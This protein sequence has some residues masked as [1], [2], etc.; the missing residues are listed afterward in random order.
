MR[1]R[2]IAGLLVMA[3]ALST[4]LQ[5][6]QPVR[7]AEEQAE[8]S[9]QHAAPVRK[10]PSPIRPVDI[11]RMIRDLSNLIYDSRTGVHWDETETDPTGADRVFGGNT[12]LA[13]YALLAAGESPDNPKLKPAIDWL[14][15]AKVHGTY[16]I[17]I[18][19][20]VYSYLPHNV[21]RAEAAQDQQFL[22][23]AMIPAIDPEDKTPAEGHG[24]Y[25]YLEKFT[26]YDH[27]DHSVSQYAVLGMWAAEQIGLT[28]P[29][30]YWRSVEQAWLRHQN[31]DGGWDY[32]GSGNN[33]GS[34][35]T[36]SAAG[37]S[38]LFITQD[39][40]RRRA[41]VRGAPP[42]QATTEPIDRGIQ[43]MAKRLET[44]MGDVTPYEL[45]GIERVGIA[46]GLKTI[47]KMDWY[48]A[49][50]RAIV[51]KY[52]SGGRLGEK[53]VVADSLYDACFCLL[54]L[55][56][57]QK[58]F[59]VNKLRYD[60][61]W[62][63][64]PRDAA[65]LTR[66]YGKRIESEL[67][68]QIL[69]IDTD[70]LEMHDAPVMLLSGA[71]QITFTNQQ[72]ASLKQF[73]EDG[74]LLV[75]SANGQDAEFTD[76]MKRMLAEFFPRHSL[77]PL[78]ADHLAMSSVQKP[79]KPVQI[80]GLS[81]GIRELCL[82][83]HEGDSPR[84]WAMMRQKERPESFE[85][86]ANILA[87]ATDKGRFRVRGDGHAVAIDPEIKAKRKATLARIQHGGN[88]NPEPGG[89]RRIS[90]L[91]HNQNSLSL[92]IEPMP[93]GQGKLVG[94]KFA[95]WTGAEPFVLSDKE[96]ADLRAFIA[97]GGTLIVDAAGGNEDFARSVERDLPRLVTGAQ[98]EQVPADDPIFADTKPKAL[99]HTKIFETDEPPPK[100][101]KVLP[102]SVNHQDGPLPVEYRR[103]ARTGT[104]APTDLDIR[105]L[106]VGRR[107]VV[108]FSPHDLSAGLV[109]QNIDGIKGYAP[110]TAT[111]IVR[112]VLVNAK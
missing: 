13:V 108:L 100:G 52:F 47:G 2:L 95:H 71:G 91:L 109:G 23:K 14:R 53:Q 20:N 57:G 78:P 44:G 75:A 97:R 12:A 85:V 89:W 51:Q 107:W 43:F 16:V 64:H 81:N 55:A 74:G 66:W 88:W 36:M 21:V 42:D 79:A 82:I 28:V 59:L 3:V 84:D 50:L 32:S 1:V 38:T 70:P 67:L 63:A 5:A 41:P 22:F 104:V 76:S 105:G 37:V 99:P 65:N 73:M 15:K 10:T 111:E 26:A 25:D 101:D 30:A 60:G 93:L 69:N 35:G 8:D 110:T 6:P 58:P 33:E 27:I 61:P 34:T 68:W 48:D 46:S 112:R 98:W 83:L 90:A 39:Y 31:K 40:L 49:G 94:H 96:L 103:F 106:K 56:R 87:Y 45:F 92:A 62:N 7:A 19:L 80:M 72:K 86:A 4:A 102:R 77:R 29:E 18:R 54:F 11:Q 24:L 17:G 9:S